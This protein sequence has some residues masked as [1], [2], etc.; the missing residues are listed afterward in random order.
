MTHPHGDANLIVSTSMQEIFLG[1]VNSAA[2][3]QRVEATEETLCYLVNLLSVFSRAKEFYE[4]TPDGLMLKPLALLYAEAL[5]ARSIDDR[6]KSLKRLGDIALFVAG[7][8]ADSLNRKL[9]DVDYYIAMG[10]NAYS[11][12]S[13]ASRGALR[14]HAF[15]NVFDELANNF[16]AFVDVLGEACEQ[17]HCHKDIDIMRTYEVWV[18]TGSKRA[19]RQLHRLGIQPALGS[20]SRTHH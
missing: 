8:F 18:R 17:A 10:G 6:N 16:T 3:N 1:L 7:V 5:A 14:W 15:S 19:E 11:Y 9:V 4:S 12:L 20:V 13:D 2:A